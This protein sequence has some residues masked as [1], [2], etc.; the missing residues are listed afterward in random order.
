MS[1][2][3]RV[4]EGIVCTYFCSRAANTCKV[5]SESGHFQNYN[6]RLVLIISLRCRQ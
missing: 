6:F 5:C 1:L 3:F 2:C 4:R